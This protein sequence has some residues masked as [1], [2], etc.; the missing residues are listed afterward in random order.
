[1]IIIG[2]SLGLFYGR[3][4]SPVKLVDTNPTDLRE[5]YKAD[6]VLTVAEAY[7]L[8]KDP[9]IALCQLVKLGNSP[10]EIIEQA[11]VFA[12]E[13]RYEPDDLVLI[14]N[15]YESI[16]GIEISGEICQ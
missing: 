5:D 4:I 16:K 8:E 9:S 3:V 15:L 6:Y 10:K 2:L 14:N 1:M 11:T 12:V 7:L 13:N